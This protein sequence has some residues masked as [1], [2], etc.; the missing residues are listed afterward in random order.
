MVYDDKRVEKKKFFLYDA[1]LSAL[2]ANVV[3]L[4]DIIYK[5]FL[6]LLTLLKCKESYIGYMCI[7]FLFLSL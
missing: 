4:Y 1:I 5:D 2:Y 3:L 6:F 7:H